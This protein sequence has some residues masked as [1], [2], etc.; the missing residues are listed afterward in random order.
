MYIYRSTVPSE[1][2]HT[3]NTRIRRPM[4]HLGTKWAHQPIYKKIYIHTKMPQSTTHGASRAPPPAP[5]S[6]GGGPPPPAPWWSSVLPESPKSSENCSSKSP[7]GC[8]TIA[9]GT[10]EVAMW[11]LQ[12]Y[13]GL[14]AKLPLTIPGAHGVHFSIRLQ[15]RDQH[16]IIYITA[17]PG[18]LFILS[19]RG[20]FF[21]YPGQ[22]RMHIFTLIKYMLISSI[23]FR[24]C[25]LW[26]FG[27]HVC[28]YLIIIHRHNPFRYILSTGM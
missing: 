5:P 6:G 11:A 2:L 3:K 27:F 22:V 24:Y 20:T 21:S 9:A 10:N 13:I 23:L 17:V 19:P 14:F 8:L 4:Q 28:R 7:I 1:C 15:P 26:V 12:L 25:S 18:P 16:P